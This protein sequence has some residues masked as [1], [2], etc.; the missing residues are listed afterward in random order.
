MLNSLS[1]LSNT[2]A[3]EDD[4]RGKTLNGAVMAFRKHRYLQNN[5]C[6][7]NSSEVLCS[8]SGVLGPC[9]NHP[10]CGIL[11]CPMPNIL[12]PTEEETW[13]RKIEGIR[14]GLLYVDKI[15]HS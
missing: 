8:G 12:R 11:V 9:N 6:L 13:I 10:F 4:R 14:E 1:S 2:V 5:L 15:T 7:L 3:F